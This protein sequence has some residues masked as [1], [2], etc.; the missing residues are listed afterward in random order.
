MNLP[1]SYIWIFTL[2]FIY[3]QA[4]HARDEF[5]FELGETVHVLSDKGYRKTRE[6]LFEAVGNV[7]I[8][9]KNQSIYGEKASMN[10]LTGETYVVGNVRYIGPTMTLY[11]SQIDYN[12]LSGLLTVYNAKIISDNYIVQGKKLSRISPEVLTGEDAEYTTCR[13][14]P[15][16]WSVFGKKVHITVGQYIRVTHAF[17]KIKGVVA[18]YVPY[19]V[20]P[21]KKNRETGLLFPRFGYN[22]NNGVRFQQPW[23][24]AIDA[25]KDATITPSIWGNRGTGGET[26]YRQALGDRK[27]FELN[28][29][30]SWD[31]I[32]TEY[33]LNNDL[34]GR[35]AFRYYGQYEHRYAVSD[36]LSHY[37]FYDDVN[38]LDMMRDYEQLISGRTGGGEVGGETF[39]DWRTQFTSFGLFGSFKQNQ[40]VKSSK[41]FDH[42]FVQIEPSLQF[43]SVPFSLLSSKDNSMLYYLGIGMNGD[44][45][46]FKQDHLEEKQYIR[47]AARLNANPFI[48]VG[49]FRN[50][51]FTLKTQAKMDYQRY[52]FPY[53]TSDK[54]FIKKGIVY[55][56]ELTSIIEKFFGMA[57]REEINSDRLD[58]KSLSHP[59]QANEGGGPLVGQLPKFQAGLSQDKFEIVH[60]SYRHTQEFKINHYY[61]S[62]QTT[63]GSDK[64]L[65]QIR[66]PNGSPNSNGIF[67]YKDIIRGKENQL[68]YRESRTGLPT[69]NTVEFQWNHSFVR[70]RPSAV[71]I[72]EDE[73]YLRNNFSYAEVAYFRISQGIDYNVKVD[74]FQER[75]TRLA[76]STGLNANKFSTSLSEYYYHQ[77]NNHVTSLAF[78]RS[79]DSWS[80]S[81]NFTYDSFTLPINKYLTAS[82]NFKPIDLASFQLI[83]DYDLAQQ[84]N[85]RTV[86]NI[87]Y[88]P[89]NKCWQLYFNYE[90]TQVQRRYSF[91]ILVN[92]NENTFTS[93][94]GM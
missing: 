75:L 61:I 85:T 49:L 36:N 78:N 7:I 40:L 72:F 60:D 1:K 21:I 54:S 81:L 65:N 68:N 53:E 64:F 74:N 10:L 35:H 79:F 94:S 84:L 3:S 5:K 14:C 12:F 59:A 62:N 50:Q 56:T 15:E 47:N 11:G 25:Q 8:T 91:N 41:T 13:D 92:F 19:M 32:Y 67:D 66:T 38:D 57:F 71:D 23:F 77:N 93:V 20:L 76:L 30:F 58:L 51:Y 43:S 31:K 37:L 29:L 39:F 4:T 52:Q 88:L 55:K 89:S 63:K 2:L 26:E 73:K 6:N 82:L 80:V 17:I 24:W 70:K 69:S 16:S 86:Y 34:S 46:N 9:Q 90:T 87:A 33:K 42:S 18:M 45:S 27:W 22:F 83:Y 28:S 44:L 48:D